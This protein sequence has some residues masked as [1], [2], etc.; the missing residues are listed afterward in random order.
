MTPGF[1]QPASLNLSAGLGEE[2]FWPSFTDVMMVVVIVFLLSSTVVV[3]HNWELIRQVQVALLEQARARQEASELSAGQTR[4]RAQLAEAEERLRFVQLEL[5]AREEA[6]AGSLAQTEALSLELQGNLERAVRQE[7][8]LLVL[9]GQLEQ[10]RTQSA[11]RERELR[12]VQER[13]A[14]LRR[15][16]ELGERMFVEVQARERQTRE[17]LAALRAEHERMG[18]RHRA[19]LRPARSALGKTV[20]A[21]R[22]QRR[23]G[24]PAYELRAP[25]AA[26]FEPLGEAEL[27][28][29]LAALKAQHGEQLF[30]R[31]VIPMDS[32]LSYQEG[33]RFSLGLLDRYDYYYQN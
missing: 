8:E 12:A 7:R 17:E 26:D 10:S 2:G 29:R 15:D 4:L 31:I 33:W 5:A 24:R 6:L 11:A 25:D 14:A 19:L 27:H 9:R 13:L 20:V 30:V 1:G 22:Y 21:V 32:G 23:D 16:K 28:R 3:L 18:R